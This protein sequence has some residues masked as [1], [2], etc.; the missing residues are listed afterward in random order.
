MRIAVQAGAQRPVYAQIA[1]WLRTYIRD[2]KLEPGARLPAVTEI[3][4]AAGVSLRTA[5]RGL[6][7][8]VTAGLCYRQPKR[9]TFVGRPLRGPGR[10][11]VCGLYHRRGHEALETDSLLLPVHR[12]FTQ[13]ADAHEVDILLLSSAD[14]RN[15]LPFYLDSGELEFAGLAMV[16]CDSLGEELELARQYP[17]MKLVHINYHLPGLED[18]PDNV[19]SVLSDEYAGGYEAGRFLAGLSRTRRAGTVTLKLSDDNYRLR[20]AGFAQAMSE[21]GV[22]LRPESQCIRPPPHNAQQT[23]GAEMARELFALPEP[24]DVI[25]CV[26]DLLAEGVVLELARLGRTDAVVCGHD[27]VLPQI[28]LQHGFSTV[29]VDFE[30]MGRK[31][32]EMLLRPGERFPKLVQ[33]MPQ[34]LPRVSTEHG[35]RNGNRGGLLERPRRSSRTTCAFGACR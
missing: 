20:L 13:V 27:N 6:N 17:A 3:A 8:L 32:A 24:P 29:T 2:R 9:G 5:E 15:S 14:L 30:G 21:L 33:L 23:L 26:N 10:R 12:G 4:A 11:R 7:E 25:F 1:A 16:N 28:S 34:L 19:H 22:A 31:A 35:A 18:S